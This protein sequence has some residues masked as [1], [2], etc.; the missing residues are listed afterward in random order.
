M[1]AEK[2]GKE[3]EER[4][5]GGGMERRISSRFLCFRL[6]TQRRRG[7]R[8]KGS[9]IR[10][11]TGAGPTGG[12]GGTPV[13]MMCGRKKGLF[14]SLSSS[15]SSAHTRIHTR[16]SCCSFPLRGC[17]SS[18]QR[19]I[20][21]ISRGDHFRPPDSLSLARQPEETVLI[22]ETLSFRKPFTRIPL[23]LSH[24]RCH[25]CQEECLC[26]RETVCV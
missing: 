26:E 22:T 5:S 20:M 21:V 4:K 14:I 1:N 24:S 19:E 16:A 8:G 3:S 15:S 11:N 17:S 9:V 23:S 6:L 13:P 25:D 10:R 12:D 7:K 2:R 18:L